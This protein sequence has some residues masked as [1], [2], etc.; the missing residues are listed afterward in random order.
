[1]VGVFGIVE[2]TGAPPGVA[3]EDDSTGSS[4]DWLVAA[5]DTFVGI[6][7]RLGISPWIRFET[8]MFIVGANVWKNIVL[9][10]LIWRKLCT[11]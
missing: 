5:T 6:D 9:S 11:Y 7:E 10:R 3:L 2:W 8:V 4:G 1:V